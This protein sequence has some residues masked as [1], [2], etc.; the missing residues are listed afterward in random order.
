MVQAE[1][2]DPAVILIIRPASLQPVEPCTVGQR[3]PDRSGGPGPVAWGLPKGPWVLHTTE[4]LGGITDRW[5]DLQAARGERFESRLLG[6][7]EVSEQRSP[8][9]LV[10]HDHRDAYLAARAMRKTRGLS[11]AWLYRYLRERPPAIVHAHYG[12]LA[13]CQILLARACRAPLIAS[14]YGFD[15]TETRFVASRRWRRAY[16]R[17]FRSATALIVEGPAMAARLRALGCP[18]SKLEIVRLPADA[19]S[20]PA[21]PKRGGSSGFQ[22]A[23]AGR[24]AEKKGFD[25]GIR[26]F[27]LAFRGVPEASLLMIGGGP[28]EE[29]YRALVAEEGISD[30]VRWGGQM[31]F[32]E[33]M[34]SLAGADI[35][36]FPSRTAA[37][38]DSEGGAP[39]TLIEAQWL[40]V[41]SIVSKHDDL[42][43]VAAPGGAIVL[44]PNAPEEWSR[45]LTAIS[46]Q[47]GRLQAMSAA[48]MRFAR[49]HHAIEA[50]TR[51]R[52]SIYAAA[53]D[54]SE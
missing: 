31:P 21:A 26:A 16:R 6:W 40:G 2:A 49:E 53:L 15:A 28:L 1:R 47:P 5:L 23:M 13:S 12:T 51:Q 27:A 41:P 34:S 45:A 36:L 52:E 39:V 24:F 10:A 19:E 54:R 17:L 46:A 33:F 30:Q 42:P 18:A 25:T 35:A 20:L 9:W 14:F 22:V 43:F 32:G 11:S 7:Y 29:R 8:H 50:N 38:G 3:K 44:P 48:A 4:R 37:D